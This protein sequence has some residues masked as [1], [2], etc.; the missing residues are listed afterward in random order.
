M[1]SRERD[2][3]DRLFCETL[4]VYAEAHPSAD[5]WQGI[6]RRLN[7]TIRF[8]FDW[9]GWLARLSGIIS[10]HQAPVIAPAHT[11]F[12]VGAG[13]LGLPSPF[14]SALTTQLTSHWRVA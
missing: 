11:P 1:N 5:V 10:V 7:T 6:E 4:Q 14:F 9:R 8:G 3:I 12:S 13:G 2:S